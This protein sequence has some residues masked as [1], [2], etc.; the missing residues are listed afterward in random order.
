MA[1]HMLQEIQEQPDVLQRILAT[2]WEAVLA[3]ARVLRERDVRYVV[4]AARGTS[5]NAAVYAKYLFEVLL[6]M[7]VSLASPSVFTRYESEMKLRNGLVIGIS[8]SGESTDVLEPVRQA[9]N[10]AAGTLAI[11]NDETSSMA[12]ASEFH[13][14]L[15]AGDEKS[16]AATK[17]YTAQLLLLYLLAFA[18]GGAEE[19]DEPVKRLPDQ[20]R[21]V[22]RT[23]WEGTA[24]YR[25]ADHLVVVSRGFN[26]ATAK[27]AAL[28][29]METSYV[30]ADGFS[31]ADLSHGP[32]AMI[33]QN[34]P[35]VFIVPP[36]QVYRDIKALVEELD[37]RG[38]E[39]VIICE[40][41]DLASRAAAKFL[42]DSSGPEELSPI[43]Y[44]LPMQLLARELSL[45]KGLNPDAPRGLSKVTETW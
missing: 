18:L 16:V 15:R 17:T 19:L 36:G 28:K 40:D 20:A 21:R 22:L 9:G 11:T 3:A 34:F 42:I 14:C 38:A 1:D 44:V 45:L 43:L 7:P 35:V 31:G 2:E 33:G 26:L 23:G 39:L 4:V 6:G 29:L 12:Q 32:I 13:L 37:D 24:R 8:Q 10:T 25:Y 41:K 27:E 30:V 5:D